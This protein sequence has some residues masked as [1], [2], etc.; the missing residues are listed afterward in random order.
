MITHL[1]SSVINREICDTFS[2][3]LISNFMRGIEDCV[4]D[5]DN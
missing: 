2:S 3:S 4:I 1:N 5:V